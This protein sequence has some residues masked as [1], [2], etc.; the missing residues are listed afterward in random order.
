MKRINMKL[1]YILPHFIQFSEQVLLCIA[2]RDDIQP[3]EDVLQ[4]ICS[5]KFCN[6]HRKTPLL[7]QI[8]EKET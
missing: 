7:E 4:N 2:A 5:Q 1:D 8:Y 6:I 3:F